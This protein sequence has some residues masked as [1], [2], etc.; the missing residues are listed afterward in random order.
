MDLNSF[1]EQNPAYA[2]KT[3]WPDE[4]L[5]TGLYNKYYKEKMSLSDFT[6]QVG[7]SPGQ[8]EP[9]AT[10]TLS[11]EQWQ[12]YADKNEA[13]SKADDEQGLVEPFVNPVD[14][15]AGPLGMPARAL[16]GKL[17][18]K[19]ITAG[20]AKAGLQGTAEK[21]AQWAAEK[22]MPSAKSAATTG[23]K[24]MATTVGSSVV[25]EPIVGQGLEL[26]ADAMTESE[27]PLAIKI[28][29]TV[30]AGMVTGTLTETA[31]QKLGTQAVEQL[32]KAG[33]KVNIENVYNILKSYKVEGADVAGAEE[34]I[35][36]NVKRRTKPASMAEAVKAITKA[37]KDK[38][39]QD[40]P[41]VLDAE[42][43]TSAVKNQGSETLAGAAPG[44]FAGV[45]QDDEGNITLD[46]KMMIAGA[47]AGAVGAKTVSK[48]LAGT[49]LPG[50]KRGDPV[51]AETRRLRAAA[52][53][54]KGFGFSP[55]EIHKETGMWQ[56]EDG[57]WR[58][59]LDDSKAKVNLDAIPKDGSTTLDLVLTNHPELYK[60]YPQLANM[61]VS[62][63]RDP[64]NKG[65]YRTGTD[66]VTNPG[67]LFVRKNDAYKDT[68]LHEVQ[69]AVQ[70][71]EGHARG[72]NP[73]W[74]L[75]MENSMRNQQKTIEFDMKQMSEGTPRK[76]EMRKEIKKIK[77][78]RKRLG[79]YDENE[80]VYETGAEYVRLN[81][82]AKALRMKRDEY[83]VGTV[84]YNKLHE[85]AMIKGKEANKASVPFEEARE[86]LNAKAYATYRN[87]LGERESSSVQ[88]RW[89]LSAEM[90]AKS[91]PV[92]KGSTIIENF[93]TNAS[94]SATTAVLGGVYNGV[95]WDEFEETGIIQVNPDDMLRGA[96][97]GVAAGA[98]IKVAGKAA[99]GW[100]SFAKNRLINP[101][102]DIVNN[103][104]TNETVRYQMG[105]NRSEEVAALLKNYKVKADL[106][107]RKA[108][109]LGRELNEM[110]PTRLGQKRLA[111]VLEGGIT[112]NPDIAKK[113]H[114]INE[115]FK[116]LKEATRDLNISQYSRFD[117]LTKKQRKELR[118]I[119]YNT[120]TPAAER[121]TASQMLQNHY[122]IGSSREYLPIFDSRIEGLTKAEKKV[123]T[124]E[125]RDLKKKSRTN[126]PE[127]DQTLEATIAELEIYLKKG[128]KAKSRVRGV[129]LDRGYS[130]MRQDI[131]A[132]STA[133]LN[134]V[135]NAGYRT[136][137]GAAT[138][139]TDVL[140]MSVLN[141][142]SKNPEW[143][144]PKHAKGTP[145]T[146]A[147]ANY[148]TLPQG[149][150]WGPLSGRK[151]RNDVLAD[152][153]EV[154]DL[155][156]NAE[157]NM[158]KI[159]GLWKYGKAILN[160]VT[161]VRN[162][163]SNMTL[164]YFAGVD[165]TN[166]GVYGSAAK[167]VKE[168]R[169]N[170]Y[171]KEAEDWGLFNGTFVD[172]DISVIRDELTEL[173]DH[174]A[175]AGWIRKAV[176]LPST[177]YDQSER[178]F[179]TAVFINERDAGKSIDDAAKHA[180][181][182][183]FNYQDLPPGV[184]HYK[185]WVAPFVT[186]TYKSTPILAEQM[187]T[188]PWKFAAVA[189]TAYGMEELARKSLGVSDDEV[190]S[191]K[192]QIPQGDSVFNVLLP[193]K[194]E[195][196]NKM[197]FNVE[198]FLPWSGIGQTWG[199][200]N[201]P[202]G[203]W[204][205]SNPIFTIG[206]AVSANKNLFSGQE[207]YDTV[208]DSTSE[209][210]GKQIGYAWKQIVPSLAPG[211]YA[212]DKLVA[213]FKN[214]FMGKEVTDYTGRKKNMPEAAMSALLGVKVTHA[215][216]QA[217]KRFTRSKL[218][219]IQFAVNRRRAAIKIAVRRNEMT[220]DEG[221]A[222][223][224]ELQDLQISKH[225]EELEDVNR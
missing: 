60:R 59:E 37:K 113:A 121:A 106:V 173:R 91:R 132:D 42:T 95:D 64:S 202:L 165:P 187:I 139:G 184:K 193:F 47:A 147:P 208:L 171:F 156:S 4:R 181:R 51:R 17:L 8:E 159:M 137:K 94:T 70:Y 11:D 27:V 210:I 169:S 9:K 19:G 168:G 77:R 216:Q 69:H 1:R 43:I 172:S 58:Y 22:A 211:G 177:A 76:T 126:N 98:G 7:L 225:L 214:D 219:K 221:H 135:V 52:K 201:V 112:T 140:K 180:E 32:T 99:T 16:A 130:A 134:R 23:L 108:V 123:L 5:A 78:E 25:A 191:D 167:A 224:K 213:G 2:D 109:S 54:L 127:G 85:Q 136:A 30:V 88:D 186:Y 197:Y 119:I 188:K 198:P 125:I 86:D 107:L 40:I 110:A 38:G 153:E 10:S 46:P 145:R 149:K 66:P 93:T 50:L 55:D 212:A 207:I 35:A 158:D 215:D 120:E 189:G 162:F 12:A 185:R 166:V 196:N 148:T 82:E 15:V 157:R 115:M 176:S 39:V 101:M 194:D 75:S 14:A 133:V 87:L 89:R 80:R 74:M 124:S 129:T 179:K 83:D 144:W 142:V 36:N 21:I 192:A 222:E 175:L 151:V 67:A 18:G 92:F 150:E 205:P 174:N 33:K 81:A 203:D 3:A 53:K 161:H 97:L 44:T 100:T 29:V 61:P 105:L 73:D 199:Q 206:A 190:K 178:F 117:E 71:I 104:V 220:S 195:Q 6:K 41:D 34:V 138:Q 72:G 170:K 128:T 102:I 131:P 116:T 96:L 143:V 146:A 28:P 49:R 164:A 204:L 160:P 31:I 103:K 223:L 152:L 141:E 114:K 163:A 45:D 183:L 65:S 209:I 57:R 68:V 154:I 24:S 200:S 48:M 79:L 118:D 63:E 217:L 218:R 13:T 111:Q 26:A 155:R 84:K 62:L 20:M 122:K 56:A 90:R 182:Y